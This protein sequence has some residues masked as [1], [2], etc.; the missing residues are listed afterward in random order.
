V[1][2][3]LGEVLDGE[4]GQRFMALVDE[5]LGPRIAPRI[6]TLQKR[7]LSYRGHQQT[8]AAL[9]PLWQLTKHHVPGND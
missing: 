4:V 5:R 2:E 6:Q 7:G 3:V 1:A 9:Q 8:D